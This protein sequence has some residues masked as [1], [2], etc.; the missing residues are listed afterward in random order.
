MITLLLVRHGRTEWSNEHR[1][2]GRAPIKLTKEGYQ[3]I[4]VI[5]PTIQM[6]EPDVIYSSPVLRAA[7]TAELIAKSVGRQV[8]QVPDLMELEVGE[9][10]GKNKENLMSVK[11]WIDYQQ[12]P[13]IAVP[14]NGEPMA[15]LIDRVVKATDSILKS[16]YQRILIATHADIIRIIICH[17]TGLPFSRL[18]SLQIGF[19]SISIIR[20]ENGR[21]TLF[22]L[23]HPYASDAG[24]KEI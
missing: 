10:Y 15:S 11:S 12:N 19:A 2:Q 18:H 13:P 17:Y 22:T 14:E 4:Q 21:P 5:L 9:W 1:V 8:I 20:W 6:W 24:A 16:G 7:Q 23:N 3:Q